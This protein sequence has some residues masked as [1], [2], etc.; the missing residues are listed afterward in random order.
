MY[1]IR[2]LGPDNPNYKA[3]G[4]RQFSNRKK[5]RAPHWN[6]GR[7]V[8]KDGYVLVVAPD[9][10]PYPA[11][12]KASGLKYILEHR[13]MFEQVIGRYL[14]PAEVVH[15]IDENPSNNTPSN[16]RLFASQRAHAAYHQ[17]QRQS[18]TRLT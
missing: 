13:L 14:K 12:T 7:K 5:E 1:G 18:S 2:K 3:P 16:L 15:H 17:Q 8:R 11:E 6:G 4:R 10:H 9:D